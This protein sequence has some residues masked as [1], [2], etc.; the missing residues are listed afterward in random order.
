M[1]EERKILVVDD[2]E[3]HRIMLRSALSADGYT[4]VEASDG[5]EAVTAVER[6][7]F[8]LILMDIRMMIEKALEHY[9]LHAENL[10]LKERLG[11]R[12]NFSRISGCHRFEDEIEKNN[13]LQLELCGPERLRKVG[14]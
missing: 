4:V 6:E 7:V 2:E 14:E 5:T 10:V 11:D 9:H 3:S 13:N 1:D 8:D 12:F